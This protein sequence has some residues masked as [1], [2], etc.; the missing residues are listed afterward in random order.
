ML[1]YAIERREEI[2]R[3]L[4][5]AL[6]HQWSI[7]FALRIALSCCYLSTSNHSSQV[8][9]GWTVRFAGMSRARGTP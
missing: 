5:L 9:S 2:K 4:E 7:Q 3:P 8:F 6:A 1:T